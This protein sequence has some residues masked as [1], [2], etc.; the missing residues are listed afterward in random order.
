MVADEVRRLDALTGGR[1][2][3]RDER[4]AFTQTCYEFDAGTTV[5]LTASF[6]ENGKPVSP[7]GELVLE[8]PR[9]K[10]RPKRIPLDGKT[11]KV[12]VDYTAPDETIK[13]SVRG[14]LRGYARGKVHLHLE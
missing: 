14:F 6:L 8:S 4:V 1:K 7:E 10:L 2:L 3:S 5:A 9:G 12:T 13:V 11:S